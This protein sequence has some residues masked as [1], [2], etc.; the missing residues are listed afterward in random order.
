M[1]IQELDQYGFTRNII[2]SESYKLILESRWHQATLYYIESGGIKYYEFF[3]KSSMFGDGDWTQTTTPHRDCTKEQM[4]ELI[5]KF[6]VH[7]RD[8]VIE[9]IIN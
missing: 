5:G 8:V 6:K 9:D 1:T 7:K 3:I 2:N 4:I